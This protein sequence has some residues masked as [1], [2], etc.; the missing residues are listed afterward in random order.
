MRTEWCKKVLI[1]FFKKSLFFARWYLYE[2]ATAPGAMS[3]KSLV[4]LWNQL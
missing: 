4:M 3:V 2:T 1:E